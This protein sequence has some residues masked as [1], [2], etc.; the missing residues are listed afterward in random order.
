MA[1]LEQCVANTRRVL[2][3]VGGTLDD[4]V[5]LTI[6][7]VHREDLPAI[8]AVLSRHFDASRAPVSA[9]NHVAGLDDW[10]RRD[11]PAR[12]GGRKRGWRPRARELAVASVSERPTAGVCRPKLMATKRAFGSR[13]S[14]RSPG[15]FEP[16]LHK[17]API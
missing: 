1:Q 2:E 16:V 11:A 7:F 13:P 15:L 17:R 14:L 8:Q 4:T 6:Y 3:A 12:A 5:S 9:L 10:R